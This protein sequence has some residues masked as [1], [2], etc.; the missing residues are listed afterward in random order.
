MPNRQKV[1][2]VGAAFLV[3]AVGFSYAFPALAPA[4]FVEQPVVVLF[5][6]DLMLDRNVA[7]AATAEALFSTSTVQLFKSADLRVLNLEGAITAEPSVAQ[8]NNKILRFTF[9]PVLAQRV[10]QQLNIS[11]V[12]SANNHALDFGE[13]GYE[14][15]HTYLEQ[16]GVASF[17]HPFNESHLFAVLE[18]RGKKICLVGYHALFV[19][20]TASIGAEVMRLKPLC[21]RTVVVAHWGE[22]YLATTTV[23]QHAEAHAL[24]DAG[25]DLIIGAHPHVV[26]PV[27]VYRDKA[28]FYSLGNFM[29]DQNFSD[30]TTRGLAVRVEFFGAKTV[31]ALIPLSIAN[32][33]STVAGEPQKSEVLQDASAVA[34]FMLP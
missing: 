30:A 20:E 32:E 24:I 31:F 21:W 6:G 3:G 29:F 27:E 12:S 33:Y 26:E 13:F 18:A 22:E 5:A 7:R 28:I 17:G 25:A 9:E 1:A 8:R 4:A 10:L 11:A 23:A 14:A 19:P 16:W 15:T 2:L 34:E